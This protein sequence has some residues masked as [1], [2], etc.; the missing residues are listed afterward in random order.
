MTLLG[1]PVLTNCAPLCRL[2]PPNVHHPEHHDNITGEDTIILLQHVTLAMLTMLDLTL[3]TAHLVTTAA[4]LV[5][6]IRATHQ[7]LL[8]H[9]SGAQHQ[10]LLLYQ[11][12]QGLDILCGL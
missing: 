9:I 1:L 4:T 5:T 12:I 2:V 8:T 6:V 10:W 11:N 7:T 3:T